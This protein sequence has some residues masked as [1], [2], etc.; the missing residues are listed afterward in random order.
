MALRPEDPGT[1]RLRAKIH[2]ERQNYDKAL[3]DLKLALVRRPDDV[4]SL[5]DRS[6]IYVKLRRPGSALQDLSAALRRQPENVD[7]LV[8]RGYLFANQDRTNEALVDLNAALERAPER[9]DALRLRG[10]VFRRTGA[11]I[12]ALADLKAADTLEPKNLDTLIELV[13]VHEKMRNYQEAVR[14]AS[15]IV[16]LKGDTKLLR[17]RG[18]AYLRLKDYAKAQADFEKV[19]AKDPKDIRALKGLASALTNQTKHDAALK[20][21]EQWLTLDGQAIEAKFQRSMTY[22]RMGQYENALTD[23]REVADAR[24][25]DANVLRRYATI[26]RRNGDTCAAINAF[27]RAMLIDTSLRGNPFA[28]WI[29]IKKDRLAGRGCKNELFLKGAPGATTAKQPAVKKVVV[30][31][32][33]KPVKP[34]TVYQTMSAIPTAGDL[35]KFYSLTGV[36]LSSEPV[37]TGI[38]LVV[39]PNGVSGG[40]AVMIPLADYNRIVG[41]Q[42]TAVGSTVS[43]QG[44]LTLNTSRREVQLRVESSNPV[45]NAPSTRTV[46]D[47]QLGRLSGND[48]NAMV[49]VRGTVVAVGRVGVTDQKENGKESKP[50][51]VY[52]IILQDATGTQKIY[53]DTAAGV[54]LEQ[55]GALQNGSQVEIIGRVQA[56]DGKG[57]VIRVAV[58]SDIRRL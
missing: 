55:S 24:G 44:K 29:I 32:A 56:T 21:Y 5:V 26:L 15:Q 7:A 30:R 17:I 31:K 11:L 41:T 36:V 10:R 49:R 35:G 2:G 34:A 51:A 19:V 58:P 1:L 48:H 14:V 33:V 53:L 50:Y 42:S 45:G 39:Q 25:G 4:K 46:S 54:V 18:D 16:E 38:R 43:V 57:I 40:V 20:V 13:R 8:A 22:Y 23:I 3:A 6:K 28:G 37:R 12:D 27:D 9:V 52:Q 47:Y